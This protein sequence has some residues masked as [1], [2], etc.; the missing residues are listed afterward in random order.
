MPSELSGGSGDA[1]QSPA[2][3][4]SKPNLL[5]FDDPTTGLDP[6]NRGKRS[7]TKSSSCATWNTSRPFW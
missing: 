1:W 5:L 4:A 6:I 2:A 7:M 3:M